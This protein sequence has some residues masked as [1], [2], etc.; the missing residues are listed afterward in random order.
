MSF[1]RES[2]GQTVSRA[3]LVVLRLYLSMV[4]L[5]AAWAKVSDIEA[6][7]ARFDNVLA[8]SGLFKPYAFYL[9]FFQE[10]VLA[11]AE[12]FAYLTAYG[13]LLIGLALLLGLCT[14][15]ASVGA[16]L[17]LA[18]YLFAKGLP[19]WI[20][21]SNDAP[22]FFIALVLLLGAAGRSFGLDHFLAKRWPHVPLW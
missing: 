7:A 21:S 1:V 17:L 19:F 8:S 10:V 2:M 6:W 12:L 22:M 13:E 5:V 4:F 14:R 16:M 18:N 11:N 15:L 20:S 9:G 3:L